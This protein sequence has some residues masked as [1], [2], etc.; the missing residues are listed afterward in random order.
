M[1][2]ATS[3]RSATAPDVAAAI[4]TELRSA[5]SEALTSLENVSPQ[6][7]EHR[8]RPGAWSPR[9]IIGHLIDSASNNHGRFVRGALHD[10]LVFPGY[11]Q[12]A[13]VTLHGYQT[14]DWTQLLQR[15]STFNEQIAAAVERISADALGRPRREHNFHQIAWRTVPAGE[16][17]TLEYFIRDYIAHLRHHLAQVSRAVG[18]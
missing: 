8:P 10:S 1:T 7:S 18:D 2:P 5:I 14:Q 3:A 13:W 4:A 16:E 12:E 9:E 11:D 15:W 17:T 6:Q